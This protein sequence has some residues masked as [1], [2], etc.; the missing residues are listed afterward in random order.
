MAAQGGKRFPRM[1][2]RLWCGL[3]NSPK[4]SI[5]EGM[6]VGTNHAYGSLWDAVSVLSAWEGTLGLGLWEW[7]G[8]P[9]RTLI[10]N[11]SNKIPVILKQP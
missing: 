6:V 4:G 10:E 7:T 8:I 1:S 5:T 9:V 2:G 3:S 11:N